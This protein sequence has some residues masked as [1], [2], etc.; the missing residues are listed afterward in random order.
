MTLYYIVTQLRQ[1]LHVIVRLLK[2]IT[3]QLCGFINLQQASARYSVCVFYASISYI[4]SYNIESSYS[5][6]GWQVN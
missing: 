6:I 5:D 3:I 2:A 1:S 4:I